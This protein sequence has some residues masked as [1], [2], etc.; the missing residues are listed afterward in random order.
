M[1]RRH[2]DDGST[3][4]GTPKLAIKYQRGPEPPGFVCSKCFAGSSGLVAARRSAPQ[5]RG[6]NETLN[7]V[8]LLFSKKYPRQ[9][10]PTTTWSQPMK[11]KVLRSRSLSSFKP[12]KTEWLLWPFMPLR[13]ITTLCGDGAVGKSTMMY[14]IIARLTNGQTMPAFGGEPELPPIKGSVIILSKEDDPQGMMRS[15]LRA[16]GADLKKVYIIGTDRSDNSDD[17]EVIERL[18]TPVAQAQIEQLIGEVNDVRMLFIDP[19]SDFS[20][21]LNIYREE[22]VRRLLSPLSDLARTHNLAVIITL[23][24]NKDTKRRPRQ[25]MLGSVA[26]ANVSRSVLMVGQSFD[27]RPT[28]TD[29]GKVQ[30]RPGQ[31]VGGICDRRRR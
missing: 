25:R 21:D 17:F 31:T 30:S 4:V 1:L 6:E 2:A 27:C 16:A 11:R 3:A 29:D 5:S 7:G 23:H 18:D 20:G 28:S 26:L 8:R 9:T 14:D 24:L 12:R 10:D 15:R 13:Q 22:H 19:A